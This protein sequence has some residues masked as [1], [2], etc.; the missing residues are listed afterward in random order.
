MT[1]RP[2]LLLIITDQQRFD[3]LSCVSD[4]VDTP[5]LDRLAREGMRFSQCVT[6]SPVCVPAR[7]SIATGW[8]PHNTGVWKNGPTT[9]PPAQ[10]TWMKSLQAAGY[11]TSLFG[12]T[13]WH[14]HQG[15]LIER[16]HVLKSY[17]FDDVNETAGPR[18]CARVRSHMT[19]R[20]EKL[21]L[22]EA[23]QND[24]EDRFKPAGKPHVVR[25][26]TL[27]LE[28]YYDTYVGEQANTYLSTYDRDQPFFC[29]VSF[30]GPHEPWDTP[31]PYASRY[32]PLDMPKARARFADPPGRPGGNIDGKMKHFDDT[33][34][35]NDND[36]AAM[37]ADYAGNV[38][39]I[40]DQVGQLLKT[41]E[42]TGQLENTVIA[43]SSDHGEMNGDAGM[44]YKENF[45]DAAVR[46]P[47]I[48][49][50]AASMPCDRG[51]VSDAPAEW[52]DL[53][54]TLADYANVP[55]DFTQFAVSQKPVVTGESPRVRDDSISEY[56]GEIMLLNDHWK[57][58]LNAE[59]RPYLLFDR[60]ED[61]DETRN[62]AGSAT[63]HAV[64]DRLRL[65]IL[66]RIIASQIGA[67]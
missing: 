59:G 19:E 25:A 2:N 63:H 27:P 13:H 52:F 40:D 42:A 9:L 24:F 44:I 60:V 61:P 58:V 43:F 6:T 3:A 49:R 30:D 50:P 65:R 57:I 34:N 67:A 26:S 41:L 14:P 12:K 8:Y 29:W 56:A 45:L 16:E 4:W 10:P 53:G 22:W 31:E 5:H 11:R 20:W 15:S 46:V 55:L 18:A 33:L 54:P 28:E 47:M 35:L 23:Y 17:G 36:I 21:G 7:R 37:R 32:S 1:S 39:L 51:F 64:E 66:E 62:L 38:T 48:I